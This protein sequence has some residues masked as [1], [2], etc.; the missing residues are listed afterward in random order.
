M[1]VSSPSP[2]PVTRTTSISR[3]GCTRIRRGRYHGTDFVFPHTRRSCTV[4]LHQ[5]RAAAASCVA[6][7]AAA[8]SASMEGPALS[9]PREVE[10]R[11]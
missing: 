11:T 6:A 8:R 1:V 3:V 7:S 9:T 2:M 5:R 10:A 4:G